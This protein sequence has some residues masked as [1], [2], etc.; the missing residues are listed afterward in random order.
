MSM[1]GNA[2]AKDD[3]VNDKAVMRAS[4][5]T[6]FINDPFYRFRCFK[7]IGYRDEAVKLSGRSKL[8]WQR[9]PKKDKK[10]PKKLE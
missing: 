7:L 10:R 3:T 6:I 5:F 8:K 4:D 2:F 9:M 1:T